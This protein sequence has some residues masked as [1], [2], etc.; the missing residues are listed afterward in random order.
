MSNIRISK[1]EEELLS[2]NEK[3]KEFINNLEEKEK[4]LNEE[5]NKEKLKYNQQILP[6]VGE[7]LYIPKDYKFR[8]N[9]EYKY[10][11]GMKLS[12]GGL[13]EVTGKHIDSKLSSCELKIR[14]E[15]DKLK[16]SYY[17]WSLMWEHFS[18]EEQN[19]LKEKYGKQVAMIDDFHYVKMEE[20]QKFQQFMED[21]D[22]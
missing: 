5:L 22:W 7:T 15:G 9:Y 21:Q 18:E 20:G 17:G 11:E 3:R 10:N 2:I 13:V 8:W 4:F 19:E 14:I 1:L 12:Q 6:K 16:G